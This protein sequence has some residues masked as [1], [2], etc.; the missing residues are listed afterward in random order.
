MTP[1]FTLEMKAACPS[2]TL[3]LSLPA[4]THRVTTQE[5]DI[6]TAVITSNVI[7]PTLEIINQQNCNNVL[8]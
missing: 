6:F 7:Q 8:Q 1:E 4:S 3:V 5:V 2:K